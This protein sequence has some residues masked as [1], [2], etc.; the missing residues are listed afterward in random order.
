VRILKIGGIVLSALIALA[1]LA[2]LCVWLF[3]NPNDYKGRIEQLVRSSTGRELSLPGKLHLS[4]F[5]WIALELGPASLGNPPGFPS[6]PFISVRHAVLRVKLLP[7]LG[8]RL[9]IGRVVID[10]LDVRL[11][12][13]AQGRGNWQ[14]LSAGGA[15]ASKA[16]QSQSVPVL[17]GLAGVVIENASVRYRDIIA[18][19]VDL[20]VG[21]VAAGRTVPVDLRLDL[22]PSRAA[23]PLELTAKLLATVEPGEQRYRL[24]SV[25]LGG[26]LHL[27]ADGPAVPWQLA[28]PDVR[29][30][31]TAR[32]LDAPAIT[33]QV[34]SARITASARGTRMGDAPIVDAAFRLEPFSPR[35]FVSRIGYAQP[36]TRDPRALSSLAASGALRYTGDE[37]QLSNLDVR[38]DDSTLR[39]SAAITNLATKASRFDLTI[40][41]IDL[42]RYRARA[43]AQPRADAEPAGKPSAI[44]TDLLKTLQTDGRVTIGR[45]TVAG[46]HLTDVHVGIASH[47]GLLR[48]AP[49]RAT[50][51]GGAYSGEISVDARGPTPLASLD[52]KMTNIDVAPLLEDF[53]KTRRLSGRGNVA[54]RLT[55][56]GRTVDA[57][58]STLNGRMT[59]DL[60]M[61]AVEG[62]DL[63]FE[64]E[65]AMSLIDKH[66]LAGGS[67]S[68]RTVF[69]TFRASADIKNGVATTRDLEIASRNL[70]VTGGGTANLVTDTIDYRVKATVLAGS[71]ANSSASGA[72]L[73][74]VP[75]TITGTFA[76]PKVRPDLRGLAESLL[77]RQVRK[78]KGRLEQQLLDR[79]KG[80]LK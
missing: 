37:V 74:D 29:I 41:D 22:T 35:E 66:T 1:A 65:R 68:G 30:D 46:V 58:L 26:T 5:P 24:D 6:Q 63:W 54:T 13:D 62:F 32:T 2:L 36:A 23:Q 56:R 44:P 72:P 73:V 12:R 45:A 57:M 9:Q 8:K 15:P 17:A 27:K 28:A 47:G 14:G 48:I 71:P 55:A 40:D 49:A 21:R 33:L 10:G 51:Y 31:L 18:D 19:H 78:Q 75:V 42:D 52:Q 20:T 11:E 79:L 77:R 39:G 80:L 64:I 61:G 38:L 70:H 59:A 50:L 67:D 76:S 69:D 60:K 4:V 43:T 3:V 7:L 34:A 16:S 25:A 53:A